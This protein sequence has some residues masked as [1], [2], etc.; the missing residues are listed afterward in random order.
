MKELISSLKIYGYDEEFSK[1]KN[2]IQ[3]NILPNK[4]LITGPKGIGKY[5]FAIHFINYVLSINEENKYNSDNLSINKLNKSFTLM[6]NYTHPCFNLIN[7][8]TSKKFIDIEQ[9]RNS[10]V[11]TQKKSFNNDKR[12]ILIDNVECLNESS[13]NALLKVLEEPPENLHFFLIHSNT[14]NLIDTIK[15]R[16]ISFKKSFSNEETVQILNMIISNF[17]ENINEC[18]LNKYH[19][20]GEIISLIKFAK[21]N[22]INIKEI[23]T[24]ELINLIILKKLYKND[25]FLSNFM[26]NLIH[27]YFYEKFKKNKNMK[28]FELYEYFIIKINQTIKYNLDIENLFNEFKNKAINE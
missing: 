25:Y 24:K 6:N 17:N 18:Y 26:P 22:E 12:F 2:L 1:L 9:I 4:I 21:D 19:S 20:I 15:S 10:I 3:S 5:T 23:Q 11:Y 8:K 13:S 14:S 7:L 27:S 16:C 28:F